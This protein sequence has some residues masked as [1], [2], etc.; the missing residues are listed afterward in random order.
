MYF[1]CTALLS[2]NFILVSVRLGN[3]TMKTPQN[4]LYPNPVHLHPLE[5]ADSRFVI[6]MII[7]L[8]GP[9]ILLF[10]R[11]SIPNFLFGLLSC[12]LSLFA[13]LPWASFFS[14]A[15]VSLYGHAI[16]STIQG[17]HL[18]MTSFGH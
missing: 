18:F 17:Q 4:R 5:L 13:S 16:H 14:K 10:V 9:C 3:R 2:L 8:N 6:F 7:L 15:T 12:P 11:E 1:L